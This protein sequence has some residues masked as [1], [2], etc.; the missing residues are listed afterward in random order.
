MISVRS[1]GKFGRNKLLHVRKRN[2]TSNSSDPFI[3][4]SLYLELLKAASHHQ[5]TTTVATLTIEV[6]GGK[7]QVGGSQMSAGTTKETGGEG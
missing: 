1:R 7:G 4:L 3:N 6:I 5:D 2:Q